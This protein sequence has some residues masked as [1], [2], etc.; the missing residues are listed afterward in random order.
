MIDFKEKTDNEIRDMIIGKPE[1]RMSETEMRYHAKLA[2]TAEEEP[3]LLS[4]I[5]IDV[6]V[7][8][9]HRIMIKA[10]TGEDYAADMILFIYQYQALQKIYNAPTILS[11]LMPRRK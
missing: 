9:L 7:P 10:Q 11:Q 6:L 3:E 5:A 8:S 1:L 4:K 2:Q